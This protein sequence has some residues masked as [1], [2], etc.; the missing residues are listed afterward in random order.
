MGAGRPAALHG[1]RRRVDP[2]PQRRRLAR[3]HRHALDQGA[4]RPPAHQRRAHHAPRREHARGERGRRSRRRAHAGA[5]SGRCS[6]SCSSSAAPSPA[7]TIRCPRRCWRWRTAPGCSCGT[8]CRST[9]WAS[10][11]LKLHS[12]QDKGLTDIREM[13]ERDQNHP[14][15]LTWSIGN[16]LPSRP[17]SG[18]EEYIKRAHTL[19]KS[20]DRHAPDGHR[21]RRLPLDPQAADP[22]QVPHRARRQRLLRLVPRPGRAARG[23][24]RP[25]RLLRPAAPVLSAPRA[26]RHRIRRGV[27]PRRPR[28][29]E[30]HLRVPDRLAAVPEQVFDQHPFI[31][32]A[33][34]WILRDFKVRPGWDGGNPTPQPPYN[35][36]GVADQNG[37]KK[38][39]FDVLARIYKNI[40]LAGEARVKAADARL[41][42]LSR[43]AGRPGRPATPRRAGRGRPRRTTRGCSPSARSRGR[44]WRGPALSLTA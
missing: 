7:C 8:R 41:H 6:S 18:Q 36:K 19:I 43:P 11:Q 42:W 38:P 29:R 20:L 22:L 9:A 39:V 34:A 26:V 30:G 17:D 21:H 15:V 16:E 40:Q 27:Q 35:Q 5:T 28:R 33:I 24:Q 4:G 37:N 3:A 25:R 2:R 10:D 12:V 14:S 1:P 13:I 44:R 23:P 31:N 32:G